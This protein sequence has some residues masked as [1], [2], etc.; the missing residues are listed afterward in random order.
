VTARLGPAASRARPPG[1]DA[2]EVWANRAGVGLILA[3]LFGAIW[4]FGATT[5]AS[6]LFWIAPQ[7]A[8]A[9]AALVIY[10]RSAS[11]ALSS[12]FLQATTVIYGLLMIAVALA[13]T[14][15]PAMLGQG[16]AGPF[17]P[18]VSTLDPFATG[19]ELAKLAG[20]S[21]LFLTGYLFGTDR[22]GGELL[23]NLLMA[24]ACLYAIWAIA[25]FVDDPQHIRGLT[26]QIHLNRL[27]A[28]FFSANT[29]GGLFGALS[30]ALAVRLIRRGRR[31][32]SLALGPVKPTLTEWAP[33]LQ[34]VAMFVIL[35]SAM[36]MTLSRGAIV[37]SLAVVSVLVVLE[38]LVAL[39]EEASATRRRRMLI[40]GC[41]VV[42]GL[43]AATFSAQVLGKFSV[44][45]ADSVSRAQIISTYR[46]LIAGTPPFGYGLGSFA[47][48]NGHVLTEAN[49]HSLWNLGAAHNIVLQWW[50]EA[51]PVGLALAIALVAVI[52]AR[53]AWRFTQSRTDRWRGGAALALGAVLLIHSLVDFPLQ[54]TAVAAVWALLLGWGAAE[55][56][57]T[58]SEATTSRA[59]GSAAR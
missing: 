30:C 55:I 21:A 53:L 11:A 58:T 15:W 25:A 48:L 18:G 16:S 44:A 41:V 52:L 34:D 37:V 59:R 13:L 22:R 12:R 56:A 43:V 23:F 27:T 54:V 42:A 32:L 39:R 40:I 20:L 1:R 17:A 31:L 36:L 47:A 3:T 33:A 7:C 50:L 28:S 9:V 19:I 46:P 2:G 49:G 24:A 6:G 10:R 26:K 57:P 8:C 35:W 4:N 14:P 5:A 38:F 51:G 29:A 45:G